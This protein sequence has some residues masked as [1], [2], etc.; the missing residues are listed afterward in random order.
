MACSGLGAVKREEFGLKPPNGQCSSSLKCPN[1]V[2][3]IVGVHH[4]VHCSSHK[5]LEDAQTQVVKPIHTYHAIGSDTCSKIEKRVAVQHTALLSAPPK[6]KCDRALHCLQGSDVRQSNTRLEPVALE[7]PAHIN[8]QPTTVTPCRAFVVRQRPEQN[9][10]ITLRHNLCVAEICT[11]SVV[12]G[13][14]NVLPGITLRNDLGSST[15]NNKYARMLQNYPGL[16][17]AVLEKSG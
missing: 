7:K 14:A 4:L 3:D 6:R 17:G 12:I 5:I 13:D 11:Q 16:P 8:S 9:T 10:P 15:W 1:G 2:V